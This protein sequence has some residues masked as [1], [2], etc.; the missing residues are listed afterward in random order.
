MRNKGGFTLIEVLIAVFV[1]TVGFVA[2]LEAFP[3]G[4]HVQKSAQMTSVAVQLS[5]SKMEEIVA[6]SY[7]EITAGTTTEDYGFDANFQ[8]FK[9]KTEVSYFDPENPLIIPGSV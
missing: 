4:A 5:Q 2:L 6:S 7:Q 3:L 8:A 9:R 1:L